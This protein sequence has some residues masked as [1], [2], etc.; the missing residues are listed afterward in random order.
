MDSTAPRKNEES[1]PARVSMV[2][3]DTAEG[4]TKLCLDSA[5][6]M[7]GGKLPN[8]YRV[9]ANAPFLQMMLVPFSAVVS[10]EGGGGVL[11]TKIK[12]MVVIKTSSLNGCAYCYAHNTA[13]GI[14]AG[15]TEEQVRAIDSDDYMSS[16][17]LSDREKAAVLWAEHV[18]K[19]TAGSRDDVFEQVRNVFNE[20]E[21]VELTLICGYFNLRN[22][23]T[24]SLRI[25]LEPEFG[26]D[27][28]KKKS[29]KVNTDKLKRYL[30][31]VV[32]NWPEEFPDP[33]PD[34]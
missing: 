3:P 12:E 25:P 22:R 32:D 9:G 29:V 4:L 10:R 33:N 28:V 11:T 30:Q 5:T 6:R 23:F 8:A 7:R 16:S 17:H 34:D 20:S 21:I 26:E 1:R 27:K 19:N 2:D 31:F 13:F 14:A 18:T 24:D 15:I